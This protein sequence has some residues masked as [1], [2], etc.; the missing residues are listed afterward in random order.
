[1]LGNTVSSQSAWASLVG[2]GVSGSELQN[3]SD[4]K[5]TEA[6]IR[7][8]RR[9]GTIIWLSPYIYICFMANLT[10]CILT[11]SLSLGNLCKAVKLGSG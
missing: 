5:E 3:R 7:R 9:G 6:R 4:L 8:K 10:K 2:N 11:I 1:M